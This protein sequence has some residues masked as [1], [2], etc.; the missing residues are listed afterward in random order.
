MFTLVEKHF[1]KMYSY[2]EVRNGKENVFP[3][4]LTNSHVI[5][6]ADFK[7]YIMKVVS[8]I[9]HIVKLNKN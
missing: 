3:K 2:L 7:N 8:P 5:W 9:S 6:Y 4:N 1:W